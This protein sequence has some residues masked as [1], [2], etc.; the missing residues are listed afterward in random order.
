MERKHNAGKGDRY[1]TVDQKK[2]DKNWERAFG[3]KKKKTKV[4]K[5]KKENSKWLKT[6][7][8]LL[9]LP[10]YYKDSKQQ[11]TNNHFLINNKN[12]SNIKIILFIIYYL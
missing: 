6:I 2:W 12:N 10:I 1:R 8:I 4:T 3:K 5:T 9:W 11:T 7:T